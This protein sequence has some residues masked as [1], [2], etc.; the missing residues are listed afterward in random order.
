M[1]SEVKGAVGVM[2]SGGDSQGMNAAVR[3]VV[4]TGIAMGIDVYAIR[5]GYQGL[6]DDQIVKMDWESVS[7]IMEQGGTVIGTARCKEFRT[8]EGRLVCAANLIKYGI[9]NLVIIGGDGS[10]TGANTFSEEWPEMLKQ[11]AE[12]GKITEAAAVAHPK[13]RI[14]GMVGSI[15]NDMANTDMTIGADTALHRI[16][17]AIDSLIS[18]ASSHQ[19]TQ[20]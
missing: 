10:L 19:R 7:G 6:V 5:E 2:T 18:T 11:L 13:L 3:A 4:R 8:Y 20:V 12:Q 15:D 1:A 17:E 9:D 14:I 16:T